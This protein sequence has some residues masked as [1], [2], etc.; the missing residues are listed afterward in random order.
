MEIWVYK[1]SSGNLASQVDNFYR[2][3][4]S[5]QGWSILQDSPNN[6]GGA[7]LVV[8]KGYKWFVVDSSYGSM[9]DFSSEVMTYIAIVFPKSIRQ[10]P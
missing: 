3:E 1:A 10:L 5:A 7:H 2:Q 8:K 6:N 4:L 9:P